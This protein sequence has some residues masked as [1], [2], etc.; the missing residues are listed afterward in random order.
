ML[1]GYVP[2]C[3]IVSMVRPTSK[4]LKK[5][6]SLMGD[7]KHMFNKNV[8]KRMVVAYREIIDI[9]KYKTMVDLR[10]LYWDKEIDEHC[11]NIAR[12]ICTAQDGFVL[13]PKSV[14]G[15]GDCSGTIKLYPKTDY[16][17]LKGLGPFPIE[18]YPQI[19]IPSGFSGEIKGISSNNENFF[20]PNC[21]VEEKTPSCIY[22][23]GHSA[24]KN[25][26]LSATN[27]VAVVVLSEHN[28]LF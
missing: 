4:N 22:I 21:V 2:A 24:D 27:V 20:V 16:L 9:L 15:N 23:T 5:I 18:V 1:S 11:K 7:K 19:T 12:N 28:V 8:L 25:I 26:F 14:F 13:G 10:V 17:N 3:F 6:F